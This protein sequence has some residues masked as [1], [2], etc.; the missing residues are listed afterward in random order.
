MPARVTRVVIDH[1]GIEEFLLGPEL[2]EACREATQDIIALAR[3]ASV[4]LASSWSAG[5][6]LPVIVG[7]YIRQSWYVANDHPAAASIEFGSGIR[8]RGATGAN[9]R[10]QGG[11]SDPQRIL[12]TAGAR[13][14]DYV[15]EPG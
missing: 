5:L 3:P 8:N 2:G 15:G 9:I 14:G 7:K 13:I 4:T 1:Q 10:P 12:G 11:Y 6:D